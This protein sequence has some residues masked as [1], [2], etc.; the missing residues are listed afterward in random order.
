ME[1]QKYLSQKYQGRD[2]FLDNI[3]F[4]IFGEE[5]FEDKYDVDVLED[6]ELVGMAERTGIKSVILYGTVSIGHTTIDVF[7]VTV[8]NRIQMRRNRVG[9]QQL[10][11]R[12]MNTYSSAFIIFHYENSNAWDWRFSYCQKDD[13]VIT[14]A[15]RYT[16]ILG[17]GQSCRTAADNFQKLIDLNGNVSRQDVVN[18]FNVEALSD[19]FF[20]K[21]KEFYKEFVAYMVDPENGMR[22]DFID[23]DFD[24]TALSE[25][26]I[27]ER[28]EKPIRDYVKRL[29]GRL[30]FLQFLQKKGWMGVPKDKEWGEGDLDFLQHLY[31]RASTEQKN[32]FL[33]AVLEPLF[34]DALDKDRGDCDDLFDTHIDGFRETKIPYLNGGLFTRD[35]LDEPRSVFPADKFERLLKFF[36]EYNFT[37][38]ENDPDDAEVGIDPEML[39]RIFEN[40]LEDNK[41]RGAYYTP[42]PVVQYMCREALIEYLQSGYKD[43][44]NAKNAI[45]DFVTNYNT[46]DID[47]LGLTCDINQKL[48][49]VKICDP[50]I[51]SGAFPMGL[52][53]ELYQCR[54]AIDGSDSATSAKIKKSIIQQNIHGVDYEKGA[55]DIARLRFWLTLILDEQSPHALPNLDFKIMQGDS[56]NEEYEGVDLTKLVSKGVTAQIFEPARDLFGNIVDRQMKMTFAKSDGFEEFQGNIAKM[57]DITERKTKLQVLESVE[58]YVLDSIAYNID[59]K[60]NVHTRLIEDLED[61]PNLTAKQK[62]ALAI[63]KAEKER[64]SEVLD[65]VSEMHVPN[66]NFFLWHTYFKDVLDNGGFDIVIGNPPYVE[67]KKLKGIASR[68]KNYEVYSGTADFSIYFLEQ[69]LN[70]CKEGGCL[71]FITTNKFFNTGYGKKVRSMIL[72]KNVSRIVNFEQVE[73]FE[74]IL[75]S[76][77]ILGIS[78]SAAMADNPIPFKQYYKLNNK[79]FKAQFSGII[80]N[81]D[82]YPQNALDEN[83]WSF[84]DAEQLLLKQKIENGHTLLGNTDGVAIYRGVTTGYNPAFII[85]NVQ[86]DE[87]ISKDARNAEV[88]KNMLQ[89]R[90]V[91]KWYYNES[92]ENMIFTRKGTKIE[93]YPYIEEH[94]EQFHNLLQPK[95]ADGSGEGRKPGNYKWFE[96]LDNTAYYREF[97]KEEKIIWGLTADKWAYTIDTE[98]H[99]LPSNAFILTS[100]E[101]PIKYILGVLNSDLLKYYFLFIG[102]M[103]AGGAYTLKGTTISALPFCVAEDMQ[104]IIDV[105]DEILNK[106]ASNHDADITDEEVRLNDLVYELYGINNKEKAIILANLIEISEAIAA[107]VNDIQERPSRRNVK[108]SQYIINDETLYDWIIR[109]ECTSVTDVQ[110]YIHENNFN[111]TVIPR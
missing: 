75:V 102:V 36:S 27:K 35:A 22:Q 105:V 106:K 9:I 29:L 87:L 26:E 30:V 93:D 45:R 37:I 6:E 49:D 99:Y 58:K 51:G 57:Y 97:E 73:V 11:L 79:E 60:R 56:L 78:N 3:V 21:Y 50:A 13:K 111:D 16:F 5:N 38:D 14:E 85:N 55:V 32:D 34:T 2:S 94:L 86:K 89:G 110:R 90:N 103:T 7:D 23:T 96:I 63:A 61:T 48:K 20:D 101:I 72:G 68:L 104:P 92:D 84:S 53:R 28:E 98:G 19:E 42:K 52:L 54:T 18:A 91:R 83:E 64:L 77:V 25:A 15:K 8:E 43:N 88:I 10:I 71:Y 24:H 39:G 109:T 107:D 82:A 74:G 47:A 95:K 46:K 70:L 69:G 100:K 33:D 12:V 80:N 44:N 40:L 1:L 108:A 31:K 41:E 4:P 17:P 62:K 59:L 65:K 66:N 81:Y 67:A 76:S